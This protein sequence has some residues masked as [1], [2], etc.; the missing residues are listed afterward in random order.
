[1]QR[2]ILTVQEESGIERFKIPGVFTSG[3]RYGL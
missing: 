2:L 1:M 3:G